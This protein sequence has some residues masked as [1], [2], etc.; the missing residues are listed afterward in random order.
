[1]EALSIFLVNIFPPGCR[2]IYREALVE[3]K[4]LTMKIFEEATKDGGYVGEYHSTGTMIFSNEE[5]IVPSFIECSLLYF[6]GFRTHVSC[7]I[8]F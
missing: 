8:S 4:V 1:M 5:E 7:S 6:P 3:N 2:Y